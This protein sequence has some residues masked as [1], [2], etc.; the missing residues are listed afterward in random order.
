MYKYI[1]TVV[2]CYD[3]KMT[4]L[5]T[6]NLITQMSQDDK[7]LGWFQ[8]PANVGYVIIGLLYGEGDF[9]ES[10]LI[11]CNCGDDTDCSCSTV[12][13]ILG[14]IHGMSIIPKDWQQYIGDDIITI[15][16]NM[17]A[18]P[19]YDN[20]FPYT[21]TDLTERIMDLHHITLEYSDVKV[22]GENT[23]FGDF[24][25]KSFMGNDFAMKL[26]NRSEYYVTF[27]SILTDGIA[28]LSG[29]PEIVPGGSIDVK[30]TLN[31]HWHSQKV[32]NVRWLL[33]E[34]WTYTGP[35]SLSVMSWELPGVGEYTITAG[36]KVDSVNRIV[37]EITCDGHYETVYVPIVLCN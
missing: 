6:R 11:A 35:K 19:K 28:E 12:G 1:T 34:G 30:I 9:K 31:L 37:A 4:W 33:P 26:A 17:G 5:E 7:E 15:S 8:S 16:I 18:G 25:A 14:I 23:D 36:D 29:E 32:H 2:E 21:C 22:C 20:L 10:M 13:S 3:K 24:D 27:N